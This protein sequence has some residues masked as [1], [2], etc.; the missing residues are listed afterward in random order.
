MK[1]YLRYLIP[2]IV[3]MFISSWILSQRNDISTEV[4]ATDAQL[5]LPSDFN[6]SILL[7]GEWEY[8]P[9]SLAATDLN[10]ELVTVPHIW[11]GEQDN[12]PDI[13]GYS[14]YR[15]F[16]SGLDHDT[17]YGVYIKDQSSAYE[18]RVNDVLII[19]NGTVGVDAAS[20]IPEWDAKRGYFNP[21]DDGTL[22]MVITIANFDNYR[23]GFWNLIQFAPATFIM[24]EQ[25]RVTNIEALTLAV[26]IVIGLF[27]LLL[28]NLSK[29]DPKASYLSIFSFLMAFRVALVGNRV[30]YD[31]L[32]TISWNLV[33]RMDY[34]LGLL[35]FPVTG[36]LL[37]WL[38]YIK[39]IR[40]LKYAYYAMALLIILFGLILDITSLNVMFSVL[41][42]VILGWAVFYF[43]QIALGL[44]KKQASAFMMFLA[45]VAM[46]A[47][48]TSEFFFNGS[49]FYFIAASL[50]MIGLMSVLV[51]DDFV[52]AQEAKRTL[53]SQ[54]SKD[55]MTGVFNRYT[56]DKMI[57]QGYHFEYPGRQL[58]LIFIDLNRFKQLND[59]HGHLIGDKVLI[60]IAHRIDDTLGK[61]GKVF[62]YGGDEFLIT[63]EA[64]NDEQVIRQV[65]H[66][67]S[68]INLGIRIERQVIAI[69]AS[70]GYTAY[71]AASEDF[72]EALKRSDEWMYHN[73]RSEGTDSLL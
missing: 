13:F 19:A 49:Q 10:P 73:K 2:I 31:F 67:H 7:G 21:N 55:P 11:T 26:F 34:I 71:H 56:L 28:S 50:S 62:R 35:L 43:Y 3:V 12:S 61:E 22:E 65:E 45:G 59:T 23:G 42:Y 69:T 44:V 9:N 68:V 33:V 16:I 52:Q 37:Y 30:I 4:Y 64:Y 5:V 29:S 15:L 48:I 24:H 47:S 53:E 57:N 39:P 70:I 14:T 20:T 1:K 8:H 60:E 17:V 38:Q 40:W 51:V 63:F 41:R 27:F 46:I 32:P 58:Y 25:E 72:Q 36:M 6:E 18:L 54:V 66:L